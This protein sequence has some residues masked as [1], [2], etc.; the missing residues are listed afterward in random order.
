MNYICCC[1]DMEEV[2]K[3]VFSIDGYSCAGPGGF[4]S[5][6][7]Q[8]CWEFIK[9]DVMAAV[10]DFFEGGANASELHRHHYYFAPQET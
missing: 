10:T 5:L 8:H 6:F 9:E 2:R 3:A 4:S 1:P 7:F